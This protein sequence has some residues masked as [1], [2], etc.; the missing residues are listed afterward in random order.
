MAA[1]PTSSATAA[2]LTMELTSRFTCLV[3]FARSSELT[4]EILG[5]ASSGCWG[6][7]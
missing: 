7:K 6:R 2:S 1:T 4:L 5:P 3:S